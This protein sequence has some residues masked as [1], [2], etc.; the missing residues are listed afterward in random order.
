MSVVSGPKTITSGLLAC[1]DFNNP[2]SLVAGPITNSQFNSGSEVSPWTVSGTNTDVSLT[3]DGLQAPVP[4][5][6][7]WKFQKSGSSSQWNGWESSYGGIWTGSS[8]DYWT[9]SYWYRTSAPAGATGFGIGS[10]YTS[11]WSRAYNTTV[12]DNVSTIIADGQWHYNYT[13]VK[14]NEAY[15]N[16]I[17]ADG[18]SWGYSS[19]AGEL[20][21]NGLQWNKNSYATNWVPGTYTAVNALRDLTGT[22][23][24]ST[25]NLSYPQGSGKSSTKTYP[26]LTSYASTTTVSTDT[27]SILNTDTHSIFFMIRFN[28]TATYPNGY[29]G[30]W[31]M[32]FQ[33][34]GGGSDRSPGI[35]RWPS[36]RTLHWR[37]D[38]GNTGCDFGLSAGTGTPFNMDTWYYVGVTK[39][40]GS[41]VMYVNGQ[42]V[43]TGSVA[44]PKTAGNAP[45]TLFPYYPQ[46]LG[47][48]GICQVYNRVL[49]SDEVSTNF[50]AIRNL[51]NL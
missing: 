16:A 10:F 34:A 12:I 48:M 37:Y 32:I 28:S 14:F 42:Q 50:S 31:D 18:P 26:Y 51:Y 19:S 4:N 27:N 3:S 8:G 41:A 38:P 39:N 43:G 36:E 15:T 21:I 49:S 6:K 35:W 23:L 45:I 13:V 22:T 25:F 44:N 5:A 9:T 7:T 20:F 11:D 24:S 2:K 30:N 1:W 47:T 40:G 33:Y 46:D 29:S 17:I